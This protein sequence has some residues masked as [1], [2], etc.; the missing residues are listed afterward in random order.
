MFRSL[1]S[2]TVP[3]VFTLAFLLLLAGC[4]DSRVI[5]GEAY[6]APFS[7]RLRSEL[8]SKSTT[9]ADLKHADHLQILDVQRRMVLVRTDKGQ[10]GWVDSTQLLSPEQM[11]ELKHRRQQQAGLPSEGTATAYEALNIHIDPDRQSPPFAQISEGA[12][13]TILGYKIV[14]KNTTALRGGLVISR[15]QPLSR[16]Q[17]RE[18]QNR[19]I[20]LKLPP[21][22]PPPKPPINWQEL[23]SER[24]D[25]GSAEPAPKATLVPLPKPGSPPK[26][27]VLE[28]W[29][30]IKTKNNQIG[31]VLTRNL[32]MSIPDEVA[33]YAEGKRIT[34]FFDLGTVNDE[35]KGPKH[36]WLWTTVA[37]A[38]PYDFDSWRVFLWNYHKHRYETSFRQRDLEGYFPV[39][40]EPADAGS[41]LRTFHL[42]TKDDDAKLRLRTYTFDGHLVHLANTEDYNSSENSARA[43]ASALNTNDLASKAPKQNWFK[44]QWAVI[45]HRFTKN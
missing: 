25:G 19:T 45:K 5:L 24:I 15:P 21:K 43:N 38:V 16:K 20:S 27:V 22:P 17:R 1:K 30:L 4:T 29:T 33:Q 41:L 2:L 42:I 44:R 26:P 37:H 8:S 14:P 9:V 6:V 40:V 3:T 36:N 34:A 31:W 7:L 11:E 18:L 28:A 35:V 23:S 39:H 32:L 12:P 10:Q 13:V